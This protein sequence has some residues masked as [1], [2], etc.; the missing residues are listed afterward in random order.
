MTR[1]VLYGPDKY[2][3]QNR[4]V[5]RRCL[6]TRSDGAEVMSDGSSFDRLA[7]PQR[8]EMPVCRRAT[9]YLYNT[10]YCPRQRW[11]YCFQHRENC[12]NTITHKPLHLARRHFARTAWTSRPGF[13][14][15]FT[16]MARRQYLALSKGWHSC[17]QIFETS[18]RMLPYGILLRKMFDGDSATYSGQLGAVGSQCLGEV[19]RV[20]SPSFLAGPFLRRSSSARP[21]PWPCP[22]AAATRC[23]LL[24]HCACA[25]VELLVGRH[26][27]PRFDAARQHLS[28]RCRPFI[29]TRL[30]WRC[31]HAPSEK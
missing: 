19:A 8:L 28:V 20:T 16:G 2:E 23:C 17:L 31:N 21:W 9:H 3:R 4:K 7:R 14:K 18:G 10:F 5:L 27:V 15:C 30:L 11:Q 12:V 1:T 6:R 22:A 24:G 26:R 13:T 29:R 25:D